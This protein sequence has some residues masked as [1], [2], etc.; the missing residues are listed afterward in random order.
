M[1]DY[2]IKAQK[3]GPRPFIKE[4]QMISY[5]GSFLYTESGSPLIAEKQVYYPPDY[6]SSNATSVVLDPKS[7]RLDGLSKQNNFSKGRPAALPIEEQFK[8]GSEVSRSL[9]GIDRAE[10]QQGLF[11]NVSSYGL[12]KKDWVAYA[13]WPDN[14]QGNNWE[15]KNSPAGPHNAVRDF[16]DAK[17][18][19]IVLDSYPVPFYNP[20]NQPVSRAV[21]GGGFAG[22][23]NTTWSKYLQG[24]VAM[25]IIEYMSNNF[26]TQQK[27]KFRM[28]YIENNYP[29][30]NGV[31]NRLYWDRIWTDIDQSR[32]GG[33]GN[34]PI[35]PLG[36]LRNFGSV[37]SEETEFLDLT[38]ATLFGAGASIFSDLNNVDV[39]FANF[40]YG[41]TRHMWT[42]PDK[43]HYR[44]KT[45]SVADMWS[46]YFGMSYADFPDDLKNW[47]FRVLASEPGADSPEVKYKLPYYLI[48]D[49]TTPS[50]SLIFGAS[51]PKSYS[52]NTIPQVTEKL[53]EGNAVGS[54]KSSY[55]V[56]TLQSTRAFRYQPGR[57]SGFTYGVRVAEE[58]AGPGT[59][60]EFGVENYSDGYFFR[61]KDGTD[62]SVVRRSTVPLGTTDLFI[63]ANY[64]EREAFVNRLTGVTTYKDVMTATEI[65]SAEQAV[66]SGEKYLIYE[67]SIE[68]N[69][70]NGDGLN[71]QGPSGYIYNPDTV[72]MYKIEFG[73]YGAIGARFYAYIPQDKGES[74]WVTLHTLVIENQIGQPCLQDPYFFFK[75]RVF[76]EDPSA[77]KLPQFVE[78]YGASYYID[79]GDEGTVQLGSGG[80]VNRPILDAETAD[81][82]NEGANFP[83]YKYSSVLGLKPKRVITNSEGTEFF[84]KKEIFPISMSVFS[85]KNCEIRF[86]NQYGCQE[87]AYTFQE[88]Y[89]CEVPESQTLRGKVL[90][91]RL[92]T[93]EDTLIDLGKKD[94]PTPTITF[95]GDSSIDS[96]FHLQGGASGGAFI[97]WDG[98]NKGLLGSKIIADKVYGAYVNPTESTG[99][100]NTAKNT[101]IIGRKTRDAEFMGR[102]K[103]SDYSNST[104]LFRY[105]NA[106]DAKFSPY[107]RDTTLLS[108]ID[109]ETEEFYILFTDRKSGT[110]YDTYENASAAPD[111]ELTCD[112]GGK[113]DGKHVG[114]MQIGIVWPYGLKTDT[115]S[116]ANYPKNLINRNNL[117]TNFGILDPKDSAAQSYTWGSGKE[118]E[119]VVDSATSDAYVKDRQIPD[120][121]NF[122][123]FEGLPIDFEDNSIKEN[124]IIANGIGWVRTSN[125]LEVGEGF[126]DGLGHIDGQLPGVP[127]E[128]GGSCRGLFVQA[129]LVEEVA[130]FIEEPANV[131]YLS[132][133]TRWDPGLESADTDLFATDI[134]S[135]TNTYITT[136]ET[137]I[138]KA[139]DGTNIREFWLPVNKAPGSSA[140][141]NEDL[142]TVKYRAIAMYEPSLLSDTARP[143]ERRITG[144]NPFPL[145]VFIKMRDGSEI[146]SVVIAK[147]T[148]NGFVNSPFTPHGCTLSVGESEADTHDGGANDASLGATKTMGVFSHPGALDPV[149][150]YS[151]I[152]TSS[153]TLEDKTKKCSSFLSRNSLDGAGFSGTG[154]YPL[155]FLK[156]KDSG[157]PVGSFY[158]SAGK[159]Q[160]ISLEEIF[161]FN[162]ES[163]TPSFWSNRALFM[164]ARDISTD[165]GDPSPGVS[166]RMSVT[167]NYK[168]Q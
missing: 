72:T 163:V 68:Q 154:D 113:C 33:D 7:Y 147:K 116:Y 58:G 122:R 49:S 127:G 164:I 18:S 13:G 162:G 74:R 21:G 22:S 108:T 66:Q 41:A 86:I 146:G 11:G 23:A 62:F 24:L 34:I 16:D 109:V 102:T 38:D 107:R 80:A 30:E 19:S 91:N 39:Y 95:S 143:L 45:N 82:A 158:I 12:D 37:N 99:F 134:L 10:T 120:G 59:V 142:I 167:L 36:E 35:L 81:Y 112:G 160:E 15:F 129:G 42:E 57:I 151:Y 166:G 153:A 29:K 138:I 52:D 47:E 8:E 123:Y 28:E 130:K 105:P 48:T 1:A 20:G 84:N 119:V 3:T 155:R 96:N 43:G 53:T 77:I 51:W 75:Y 128:D 106:I 115:T 64:Q 118:V 94:L 14:N 139:I 46:E 117:G 144:A 137:Q 85:N 4:L 152:D 78:K 79:G 73:W 6:L 89:R 54:R 40:F 87:H 56:Q 141:G 97:G 26:T 92:E 150:N 90:I 140:F 124:V 76:V 63:E 121:D 125:A 103:M 101:T 168:E 104:L 98:L 88:G 165:V 145:R 32:V 111:F 136:G 17:N 25:Y 31:F 110:G 133:S 126:T 156:F 131:Y 71:N 159:P 161:N 148:P 149:V 69:T 60:L 83:V 61:L 55:A 2:R 132:K 5:R 65:N 157:D 114:D 44:I 9:L 50:E 100:I 67:T 70:M 93:D 27:A 135:V